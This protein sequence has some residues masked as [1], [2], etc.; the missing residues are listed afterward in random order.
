[1][2]NSQ[3]TKLSRRTIVQGLVCGGAFLATPSI[4]RVSDAYAATK[5]YEIAHA[6]VT[7]EYVRKGGGLTYVNLHGNETTSVAAARAV[8][9]KRGGTLMIL[10]HGG[11]RN[12]TFT[13]AGKQYAFDPNRMF[14]DKGIEASLRKLSKAWT[15]EAHIEVK[16][17]AESIIKDFGLRSPK[18]GMVVA[19]HN[20]T[21]GGG[22]TIKSYKKGG[23]IYRTE[24]TEMYE[25]P[26]RD[27]DDFFLVTSSRLFGSLKQKKFNVALHASR[28]FQ[29]DGSLSVFCVQNGISY[30]NVEA[31]NSHLN[32]QIKMLE[33]LHGV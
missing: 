6:K 23:G 11:K 1:M 4:V 19:L 28:G 2:S 31:E 16:N 12:V 26:A 33:A 24:A 22:L 30:V 10:R 3:S 27:P 17:I 5:T 8:I 29:D 25:N 14:T 7:I 18:G 20:N 32:E 9:K 13:Y 21:N 15:P